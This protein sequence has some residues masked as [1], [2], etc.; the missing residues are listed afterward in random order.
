MVS[1][2]YVIWGVLGES[3]GSNSVIQSTN[4]R[5]TTGIVGATQ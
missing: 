5:L 2:N 4:Y 1:T 3:P